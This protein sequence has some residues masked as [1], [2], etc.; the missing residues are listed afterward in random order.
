MSAQALINEPM[1]R[2]LSEIKRAAILLAASE[3]VAREGVEAATARIARKASV[4]EGTVFTYFETK[5]ALLNSLYLSIKARVAEA[6]VT[7]IACDGSASDGLRVI[8]NNYLRWGIDNPA[9]RRSLAQLAVSDRVSDDTRA[10][11]SRAFDAVDEMLEALIAE[12]FVRSTEFASAIMSALAEVTI[13]F[14]LADPSHSETIARD[15][16]SA[17]H[18]AL[19]GSS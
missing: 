9:E 5:D 8:W 2:P 4:A 14:M 11:A 10:Q 18:R 6:V 15:G 19:S 3:I 16:F 17:L 13:Q 12:R 1:A 7:G